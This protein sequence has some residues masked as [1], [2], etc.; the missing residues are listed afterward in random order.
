MSELWFYHLEHQP[1]EHVLPRIIA[2]MQARGDVICVHATSEASLQ[3]VSSNLWKYEDTSFLAHGIAG[4]CNA[5]E[6]PVLLTCDAVAHNAAPYRFYIKGAMPEEFSGMTRASVFF[7]GAASDELEHA[8]ALWRR[9]SAAGCTV[10][11]WRQ[12]AQG[13]WQD[14]AAQQAA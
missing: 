3:E 7:D 10:R 14:Q 2:G 12:S 1:L 4:S 6:M 13:R 5:S 9:A 11:Y 8:R